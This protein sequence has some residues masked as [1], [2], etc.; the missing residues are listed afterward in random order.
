M[1]V[2]LMKLSNSRCAYTGDSIND[3]L[4]LS[5]A[6]VG[7]GMG[8]GCDVAKDSSD[9][10]VLDNNFYSVFHAVNWGRNIY[11]NCR[12]FIQFQVTVNISTLFIVILGGATLGRSPFSII[13]LLWINLVM[14]VLAALAFATEAPHP[15]QLKKNRI[16]ISDNM[17]LPVMWRSIFSQVIY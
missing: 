13:Q 1:F 14:D 17:I 8:G 5:E 16:K 6:N 11:D 9:I 3:A 12:K 2:A 15:G 10:I 7:F 4:A